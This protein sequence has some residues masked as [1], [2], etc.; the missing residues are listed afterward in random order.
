MHRIKVVS[1]EV[2]SREFYWAAADSPHVLDMSFL[3]FGLHNTPDKLREAIQSAV[4]EVDP[5][6]YDYV[7]LGYCLCSRG[8]ADIVGGSVPLVVP[9]GHDCITVFLG[10]RATYD[11]EFG[12]HPGTYYYSAGWIERKEGESSQ[13]SIDDVQARQYE[14]RYREYVEKYGEDNAKYLIEQEASWHA[15]YTRAAFID[16]QVGP[17]QQYRQF[18]KGIARDREWDYAE[19]EGSTDMVR[20]LLHGEWDSEDFL[21]VPPHHRICESFDELILG[22]RDCSDECGSRS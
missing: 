6:V 13:G 21:V 8:T 10:S 2:F 9:R 19:I 1:C 15:N 11:R 3:P 16:T 14:E 4:D 5:E 18:V 17:C 22:C 12:L 20:R 7:V